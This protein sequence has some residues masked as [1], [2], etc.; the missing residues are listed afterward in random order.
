MCI[1]AA[2]GIGE[3]QHLKINDGELGQL[4]ELQRPE[5]R[6]S[7]LSIIKEPASTWVGTISVADNGGNFQWQ[8]TGAHGMTA[9]E[10][11]NTSDAGAAIR[12]LAAVNNNPSGYYDILSVDSDNNLT[13]TNRSALTCAATASIAGTTMTVSAV[14]AGKRIFLGATISG[15]GVTA[16]TITAFG[17]GAGGTGTYTVSVSQTVASTTITTS[18]AARSLTY[19]RAVAS[20]LGSPAAQVSLAPAGGYPYGTDPL[21]NVFSYDPGITGDSMGYVPS[22]KHLI[23]FCVTELKC[24]Y[25]M[26]TYDT[27]VN[28]R[29]GLPNDEDFVRYLNSMEGKHTF[30]GGLV[31]TR[32]SNV[33]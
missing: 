2:P 12:L 24:R 19:A 30:G 11:V 27:E 21:G 3:F 22:K 29:S 33:T 6:Y 10:T 8:S 15:S 23:D 18:L 20:G 25:I 13:V 16:A 1:N 26:I 17:T 31:L 7:N 28:T 9:G 14:P 5:M 32:P 4:V